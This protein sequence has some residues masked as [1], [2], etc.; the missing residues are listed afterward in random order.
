MPVS[1]RLSPAALFA[2]LVGFLLLR[3]ALFA[4]T[5]ATEFALYLDYANAARST[6]MAELHQSR[7]I[8]Y[9]PLATLFGVAVLHVAEA[10]PEGAER[11]TVLRPEET[12]GVGP[13]RYEVAL[14][15]V[16]FA[17]DVACLVFVYFLARRV[18]PDDDSVK[19]F[20]RLALYVAATTAIG[21]ILYDRQDL[22][23]G[24]VAVMM[25]AAVARG[26]SLPAYAILAVGVAYKLVPVLLLPPCVLALATL[27]TP[28]S[29]AR[30]LRTV[31]IE[32]AVAGAILALVPLLMYLLC[33]GERAFAFLTF[34]STRGLQLEASAAWPVI[35]LDSDTRLGHSFGSYT[36]R[37]DLADRVARLCSFATALG[38]MLCLLIATHGFWRAATSDRPV[39][40]NELVTHLVASSLLAWLGFILF[41]K[42]GSPQYLLW[43]APLV[44]LLPLRG[45]DR[46]WSAL[47]LIGMVVTTLIYPCRYFREIRGTPT[48]EA[49][50]W[51]GPSPLGLALL[52][53]K[54]VVFAVAFAWLAVLVWRA[55][56]IS[57]D[58]SPHSEVV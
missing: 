27:R 7:D 22:V 48:G 40:R 56:W 52:A 29:T 37:G 39:N 23:V 53:A 34:H 15:L 11:L 57:N 13:A 44:P 30:F 14:G 1:R 25:L 54:S 43:L 16:L 47:L 12:R 20:T 10:L 41:S 42:V 49:N 5:T 2:L 55:R 24:L 18:Y 51:S 4:V 50:T 9:P 32:A 6:S 28:G 35:L 46:W 33:G 21:L 19:R 58:T 36:L 3:V 38:A 45:S 17:V 26:W 31:M 8:E